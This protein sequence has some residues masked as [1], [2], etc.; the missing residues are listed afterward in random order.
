MLLSKVESIPRCI[1]PSQ[2]QRLGSQLLS[3]ARPTAGS[4]EEGTDGPSP[5]KSC[6]GPYMPC[7][8]KCELGRTW[9]IV[10]FARAPEKQTPSR[11]RSSPE[12]IQD[13]R[14]IGC[15]GFPIRTTRATA[16]KG[17]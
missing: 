13:F 5:V 14:R 8:P 17:R 9:Y 1:H 12:Q 2:H 4:W 6:C 7:P 3:I 16:R 15:K 10:Q 11:N